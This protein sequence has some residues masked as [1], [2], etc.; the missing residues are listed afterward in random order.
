MSGK[1]IFNLLEITFEAILYNTLYK[2]IGRNWDKC[3]GFFTLGMRTKT[4]SVMHVADSVPSTILRTALVTSSPHVSQWFW[5][6]WA[7]KPLGPGAFVGNIWK[8]A[9]SLPFGYTGHLTDHSYLE[10]LWSA[11]CP[12]P[13]PCHEHPL[14]CTIADR[15]M[16]SSFPSQA[17][18]L[19]PV[20]P[21][22]E[23]ILSDFFLLRL[24]A[25]R[26]KKYVFLSPCDSHSNL[27]LWRHNITT[28]KRHFHDDTCLSQ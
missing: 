27:A 10:W 15:R 2:L 17:H 26:W 3:V 13:A 7:G 1:T 12:G 18:F 23:A 22:F 11:P 4:V 6:K 14:T 5:K 20:H 19:L 8:R 16:L 28:K 21:P 24:L 25:R 9:F